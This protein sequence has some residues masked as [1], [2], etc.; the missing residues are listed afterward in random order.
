M[1]VVQV[2][3]SLMRFPSRCKPNGE[4]VA[5][6]GL[7]VTISLVTA[8]AVGISRRSV[9]LKPSTSKI[10]VVAMMMLSFEEANC[11]ANVT[12]AG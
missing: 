3:P 9:D 10:A 11:H 4:L 8:V 12:N 6:Q 5:H 2:G 1:L 7:G